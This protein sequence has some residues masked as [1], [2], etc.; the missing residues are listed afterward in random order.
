MEY[1]KTLNINNSSRLF[2]LNL[3]LLND[4]KDFTV[5]SPFNEQK[6]TGIMN[7]LDKESSRFNHR[8]EAHYLVYHSKVDDDDLVDKLFD[9][10]GEVSYYTE[11]LVPYHVMKK[12]AQCPVSE[13]IFS[14][15]KSYSDQEVRNI[16]MTASATQTA[17]DMSVV[18]PDLNPYDCLFSLFDLRYNV[19]KIRLTFPPL[20][21][22]EMSPSKN[23]YYTYN[24]EDQL[25][26][27]KTRYKW[28]FYKVVKESLSKWKMNIW[29]VCESEDEKST[30]LRWAYPKKYQDKEDDGNAAEQV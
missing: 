30:I 11:G 23:E 28:D 10:A 12:M 22:Q 8:D 17:I 27:M 16:Q 29:F 19:D 4:L 18:L 1:V 14:L 20:T 2:N 15:R 26:H 7:K 24:S 3:I 21:S 9:H 6:I 13:A 5:V 25:F